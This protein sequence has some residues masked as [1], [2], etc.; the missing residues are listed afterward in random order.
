MVNPA[1]LFGCIKRGKTVYDAVHTERTQEK[2]HCPECG[3]QR[4]GKLMKKQSLKNNG[5]NLQTGKQKVDG[6]RTVGSK[7]LNRPQ[8]LVVFGAQK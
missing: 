2:L 5:N 7:V 8:N 3:A 4:R 1:V 6:K